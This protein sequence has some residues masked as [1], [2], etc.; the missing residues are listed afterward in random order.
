MNAQPTWGLLLISLIA[1][2]GLLFVALV[3]VATVLIASRDSLV[4]WQKLKSAFAVLVWVIPA[5]AVVTLIGWR[6]QPSWVV[7]PTLHSAPHAPHAPIAPRAP[8]APRMVVARTSEQRKPNDAEVASPPQKIEAQTAAF[9]AQTN[10]V[11]PTSTTANAETST[12]SPPRLKVRQISSDDPKWTTQSNIVNGREL[13]VL[14][15]ERFAT[16]AEA[17]ENVT[18]MALAKI[19]E[20]WSADATL[21]L[22]GIELERQR[23][24][25]LARGGFPFPLAQSIESW[26]TS[27]VQAFIDLADR[28]AVKDLVGEVMDWD[29]KNG[30]TGKMYRAH[31]RLDF[32]PEFHGALQTAARGKVVEHRMLIFG[33]MLGLVTLMLGTAAGY[34]KL[35]D[36]TAGAY[37][38]RLKL[39]AG[40][41]IA[42]GGLATA[43]ILGS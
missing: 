2:A 13:V 21:G 31:L 27:D 10:I 15:S 24:R 1:V 34:F 39:A 43:Q 42:A 41:L 4:V 11:E 8:N 29:F 36:A 5:T 26:R 35:D 16:L 25:L 40:A 38:R 33:G 18:R 30:T 3:I 12:A 9:H 19:K 22:S 20:H 14:S 7:A 37:R 17:E 6:L 28:Y 23:Q 32:S